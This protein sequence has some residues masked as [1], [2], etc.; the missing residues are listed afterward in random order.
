PDTSANHASVSTAPSALQASGRLSSAG[1]QFQGSGTKHPYP[2]SLS[3]TSHPTRLAAVSLLRSLGLGRASPRRIEAQR[4]LLPY[5][6]ARAE[7]VPPFSFLLQS[8]LPLLRQD[9]GCLPP[10]A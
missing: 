2:R 9:R 5:A 1:S 4:P 10:L 3:V 7:S 6:A 8:E